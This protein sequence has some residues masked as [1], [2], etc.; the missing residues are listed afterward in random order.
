MLSS[1]NKESTWKVRTASFA[2]RLLLNFSSSFPA[3]LPPNRSCSST[4]TGLCTLCISYPDALPGKLFSKPYPLVH[5]SRL[6]WVELDTCFSPL[7]II[8]LWVCLPN[9]TTSQCYFQISAVFAKN[10][11]D[12]CQRLMC[13]VWFGNSCLEFRIQIL[14]GWQDYYVF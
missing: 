11:V 9:W 5:I 2:V 12:A 7:H 13:F 4:L 8:H 1:G 10:I 3:V 14:I 6:S